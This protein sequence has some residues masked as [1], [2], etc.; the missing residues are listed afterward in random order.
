MYQ[1]HFVYKGLSFNS[2][3]RTWWYA[4][5]HSTDLTFALKKRS[6]VFTDIAADV[7]TDLSAMNVSEAFL[8][9]P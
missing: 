1:R 6:L 8:S 2:V 9:W 3:M 4:R 5:S 7:K